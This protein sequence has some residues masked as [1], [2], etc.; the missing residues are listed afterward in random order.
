MPYGEEQ[1]KIKLPTYG[2]EKASKTV[3]IGD[4]KVKITWEPQLGTR[5]FTGKVINPVNK[6]IIVV[7]NN[8]Y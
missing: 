2:Y 3:K 8:R 5:G 1:K 6:D 4:L 7:I